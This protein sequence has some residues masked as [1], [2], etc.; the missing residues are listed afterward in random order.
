MI[1]TFIHIFF[2]FDVFPFS[3]DLCFLL[4]SI[5]FT[6]NDFNVFW[7]S[8]LLITDSFI[9]I[10]LKI[11]VFIFKVHFQLFR[12]WDWKG[13]FVAVCFLIS[14]LYDVIPL[15]LAS[16]VF[17]EKLVTCVLLLIYIYIIYDFLWQRSWFSIYLWLSAV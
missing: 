6:Q 10:D 7:S 8:S 16:I 14:E 2:I 13:F 4:M 11:F 9:F 5:S 1:F 15:Y 12:I 3:V 17:N